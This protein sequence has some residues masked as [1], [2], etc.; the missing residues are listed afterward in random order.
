MSELEVAAAELAR[1]LVH[2]LLSDG[3]EP[4]L[5]RRLVRLRRARLEHLQR[6]EA[7]W[8]HDRRRI[9]QLIGM[10]ADAPSHAI[11]DRVG[12]LAEATRTRPTW[13]EAFEVFE[14]DFDELLIA[15]RALLQKL[16]DREDAHAAVTELQDVVRRIDRRVQP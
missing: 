6:T 8:Q 7:A 10:D 13:R 14:P 15:A 16:A 9:A 3:G 4:D 12:Y 1:G 11:A 2:A 5:N